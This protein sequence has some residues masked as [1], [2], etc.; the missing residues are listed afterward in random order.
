[1]RDFAVVDKIGFA[2]DVARGCVFVDGRL[3]CVADLGEGLG[4]RERGCSTESS[5]RA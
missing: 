4:S 1:M 3:G 2:G 5:F